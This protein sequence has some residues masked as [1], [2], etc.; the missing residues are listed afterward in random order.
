MRMRSTRASKNTGSRGY[1]Y[2]YLRI[3]EAYNRRTGFSELQVFND[4]GVNLARGLPVTN[5]GTWGSG[6]N[7]ALTNGSTGADDFYVDW[8]W[9]IGWL[10][11][12][13]GA[14]VKL[15]SIVYWGS[16]SWEPLRAAGFA[17]YASRGAIPNPTAQNLNANANLLLARTP[18]LS[19]SQNVT[20]PVV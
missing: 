5:S 15:K 7:L 1:R 12:D 13:L 2:I 19:A 20:L 3:D 11:L 6:T 10:C 9:P 18:T 16:P 4:A 8:S 14:I 17:I